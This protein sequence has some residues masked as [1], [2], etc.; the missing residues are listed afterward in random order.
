MP[1]VTKQIREGTYYEKSIRHHY[2]Y[3]ILAIGERTPEGK[4]LCPVLEFFEEQRAKDRD[5]LINLS[6][7]LELTARQGP[8]KN[9]TKFKRVEG[10]D[11]VFEFKEY[12]HRLLCFWDTGNTI[13]CTNGCVKKGDRLGRVVTEAAEQWK[14]RYFE[15][16]KRN[17]LK[18][19]R[20]H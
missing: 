16:K 10:S 17:E 6:A 7:L 18:H 2:Q 8:P 14:K 3:R 13:V 19:E 20:E 11:G 4:L 9:K 15:A 12:Q 5:R 1:L